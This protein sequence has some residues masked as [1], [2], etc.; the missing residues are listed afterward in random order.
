[1]LLFCKSWI[2]FFFLYIYT[3]H[4]KSQHHRRVLC[5]QYTM[6]VV[7]YK[8]FLLWLVLSS[9]I[10]AHI[11]SNNNQPK[12]ADTQNHN[13]SLWKKKN[14]VYRE[15]ERRTVRFDSV[16]CITIQRIRMIFKQIPVFQ[17]CYFFPV[18]TKS[19]K[20]VKRNFGSK[21]NF[22]LDFVLL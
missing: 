12:H 21:D 15:G 17:F 8:L 22:F 3:I 11:I 6:F 18:L 1:M 7:F 20:L 10:L 2:I 13:K 9:F 16:Q 14:I 19:E 4:N 5:A